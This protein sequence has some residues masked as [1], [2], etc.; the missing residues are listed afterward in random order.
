MCPH[1]NMKPCAL[2]LSEPLTETV[3]QFSRK[4]R[5]PVESHCLKGQ[6]PSVLPAYDKSADQMFNR[7]K[8][9]ANRQTNQ[10]LCLLAQMG[11]PAARDSES[12]LML[13]LVHRICSSGRVTEAENGRLFMWTG[14]EHN[15]FG[16]ITSLVLLW[17]NIYAITSDRVNTSKVQFD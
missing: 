7:R 6:N 14:E 5:P 1:D 10:I 17:G 12:M 11:I 8:R 15:K 16:A 3:S 9:P 4:P 2:E 13:L